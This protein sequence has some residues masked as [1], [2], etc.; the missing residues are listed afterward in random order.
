MSLYQQRVIRRLALG[1]IFGQ[2]M[3]MAR[4]ASGHS[5]E[6][7]ARLAGMEVSQWMAIEA[8]CVP[9]PGQLRPMA[10]ALELSHQSPE[11]IAIRLRYG[12]GD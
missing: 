8:G 5:V 10:D 4:Q 1:Q 6:E 3:Q 12:G 9:D 2:L 11:H 7:A